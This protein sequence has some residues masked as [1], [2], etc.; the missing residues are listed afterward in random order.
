LIIIIIIINTTLYST[1]GR[2][3][4]TYAAW[5]WTVLCIIGGR[6]QCGLQV[7][8]EGGEWGSRLKARFKRI[9]HRGDSCRKGA[10]CKISA[11]TAYRPVLEITQHSARAQNHVSVQPCRKSF[12]TI[13]LG[14]HHFPLT[15]S[16]FGNLKAF[17]AIF[18]HIFTAHAQKQLFVNFW[19]KFWHHHS[20]P[21]PQF[22]YRARYFRDLRMFSVDFCIG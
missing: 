21:W 11:K 7:G 22:P 5:Q 15:A 2:M 17:R 1:Q 3:R 20:I 14:D 6:E 16:N 8:F 18:G 12:T 10:W 19:L 9:P 13:V 4:I